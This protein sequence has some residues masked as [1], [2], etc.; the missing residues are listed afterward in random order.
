MGVCEAMSVVIR[1]RSIKMEDTTLPVL[2]NCSCCPYGYHID[3]DFVR[4]CEAVA[5]AELSDGQRQR[6]YRRRQTKS[7]EVMLGLESTMPMELLLKD[8][9][10]I[11]VNHKQP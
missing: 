3:I 7:M 5:H 2:P 4:Y 6:R 10:L 11:E 9:A 8:H 1:S